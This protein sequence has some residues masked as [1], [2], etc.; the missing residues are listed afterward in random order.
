MSFSGPH[1]DQGGG[2]SKGYDMRQVKKSFASLPAVAAV[3]L[4]VWSLSLSARADDDTKDKFAAVNTRITSADA[5]AYDAKQ[6][7]AVANTTAQTAQ[8]SAQQANQRI[9]QLT[10]MVNNLEQRLSSVST[11]ATRSARN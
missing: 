6:S 10:Q 11:S 8:A 7:A 1:F 5:Q 9:D 4:G 3:V 2:F